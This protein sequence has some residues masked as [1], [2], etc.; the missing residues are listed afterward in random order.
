[1]PS[2]GSLGHGHQDGVVLTSFCAKTTAVKGERAGGAK[3]VNKND[4]HPLV[5][6]KQTKAIEKRVVFV[7]LC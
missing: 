5:E 2:T 3:E 6:E 4:R 7:I 1:M